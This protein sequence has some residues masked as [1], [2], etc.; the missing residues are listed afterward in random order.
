MRRILHVITT[1]SRGGAENQLLILARAQHKTGS[2]VEVIY[3]KGEPELLDDFE[4]SGVSVNSSLQGKHPLIQ[5]LLLRKYL[6]GYTGVVHAHLPRAE[7]L[8]AL[9][10]QD[11]LFSRHNAEA[12]FPGAP[13]MLSV[14]LSRMVSYRARIG[15]AISE[16]VKTFLYESV[17]INKRCDIPV[18]Y[19]GIEP[20]SKKNELTP[21]IA[22]I[23][24]KI[25]TISRLVPQKDLYTLIRAY[26]LVLSEFPDAELFIVGSGEL[27]YELKEFAKNLGVDS[28]IRWLG[29]MADTESFY[30]SINT[31]VL[32]STYEGF[33]LVLLEA[34][35][36]GVPVVATNISAIPEVIG[37]D[38]PLISELSHAESFANNI[39]KS[40]S[41]SNRESILAY[42]SSR[43]A[44][45]STDTLI[46]KLELFYGKI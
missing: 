13:R 7:L 23:H 22:G 42:Q 8:S 46:D 39:L 1:I 36:Y 32:S 16:A 14:L 6:R 25:G 26:S 44:R 12:F 2:E 30:L 24:P 18:V 41:P 38:H 4:S 28:Q 37:S 11:F 31:F 5:L 19:Y 10:T 21:T 3:L 9:S 15:I 35:N 34:M 20:V 40:L 33:G 45:F 43:V 17:E 27:E 29:R